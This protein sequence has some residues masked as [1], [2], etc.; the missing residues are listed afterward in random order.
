MV[1]EYLYK[2]REYRNRLLQQRREQVVASL[3][4]VAHQG[5]EE[6]EQAE[7][8]AIEH[9]QVSMDDG[10]QQELDEYM[11]GVLKKRFTPQ[12]LEILAEFEVRKP[13]IRNDRCGSAERV[14]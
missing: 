13:T 12:L 8:M 2:Y 6:E 3:R 11:Q 4:S 14:C 7:A 5:E 9:V 10:M 1:G